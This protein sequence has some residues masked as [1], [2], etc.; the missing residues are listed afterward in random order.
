[1]NFTFIKYDKYMKIC[2]NHKKMVI[3]I[4]KLKK[5]RDLYNFYILSLLCTED[6]SKIE[7]FYNDIYNKYVY[8]VVTEKF[9]K[10]MYFTKYKEVINFDV[11]YFRNPFLSKEPKRETSVKKQKKI[12]KEVDTYIKAY[13]INL[14]EIID[15]YLS[16]ILDGVCGETNEIIEYEKKIYLLSCVKTFNKDIYSNVMRFM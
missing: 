12:I 7:R 9:W 15:K 16:E 11:D 1:M 10:C 5:Y 6:T 14:V 3:E 4:H 2:V 8:G 13:Q